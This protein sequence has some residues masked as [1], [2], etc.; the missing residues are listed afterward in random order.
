[1]SPGTTPVTGATETLRIAAESTVTARVA[2]IE[3]VEVTAATMVAGPGRA[4]VQTPALVMDPLAVGST[5]QVTSPDVAGRV[6]PP[7][8]TVALKV[9]GTCSTNFP[10]G[11]VRVTAVGPL[12]AVGVVGPSLPPP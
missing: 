11:A 2:R 1:M 5:D 12:G 9:A 6:E 7:T 10:A 4:G 8:R 3:G